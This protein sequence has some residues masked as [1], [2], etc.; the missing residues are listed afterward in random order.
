MKSVLLKI[1]LKNESGR[2]YFSLDSHK[3]TC[4]PDE[5]EILLQAGLLFV[6]DEIKKDEELTVI[7]MHSSEKMIS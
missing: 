1:T 4:Y 2:H 7:E 6:I 3:F 5:R